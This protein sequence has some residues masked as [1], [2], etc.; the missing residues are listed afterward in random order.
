MNIWP[1]SFEFPSAIAVAKQNPN[2]MKNM[3]LKYLTFT[4]PILVG[5]RLHV[6]ASNGLAIRAAALNVS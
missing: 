6:N 1:V 4:E 5:C 2:T 3:P